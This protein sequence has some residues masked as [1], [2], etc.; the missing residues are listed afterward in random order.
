MMSRL[1][2]LIRQS[3]Q[4]RTKS[5]LTRRNFG[6][7]H[8]DLPLG[9]SLISAGLLRREDLQ[10]SLAR[11]SIS[12]GRLGELLIEVGLI[13]EDRLLPFLGQRLGV[14]GVRLRDGMV[15]PHV[16]RTLPRSIAERLSVL[17]MF[18]V[19][20]TLTVAMAD[21]QD[22]L[23]ID[24]IEQLTGL[25]VRPVLAL[26]SSIERFL[27]RC[28]EDD[29]GTN[30]VA[31]SF[32]DNA[33]E[34]HPEVVRVD[35]N[36]LNEQVEGSPIISMVN[37]ILVHAVRQGASDI[38]I[39]AGRKHS[40]VR[41][42]VDGRLREVLRPRGDFHA[43]LIS[44][45]KAMARMDIAEN[46]R[47][48]DGRVHVIVEGRE[49]DLRASTLPTVL[50]EK[51]VLRVLDSTSVTFRMGD[52]GVS[53]SQQSQIEAMMK[54]PHG[55]ILVTGPTGSGKT[56]TLY[57]A[58]ELIKDIHTNIVT[59]EDPVEY[60][61]DL[62]NQVDAAQGSQVTFASA[63]RAILR[64]DPDVIMIG[65]IRDAETAEIATQA[66]LTGHLVLSTLHANDNAGAITRLR[67][68]GIASYKLSASLVGVV[69]QRLLR[70][71]CPKCQ[72]NYFPSSEV[73]DRLG[74]KGD[75]RRQFVRGEGCP[76]CFDTG[77]RGR[78]GIYEVL[79]VTEGLREMMT[80]E[81]NSHSVRRW[82]Q[83]NGGQLLLQQGIVL[84]EKGLTSPDEVLRVAATD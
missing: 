9:E 29:A 50:G 67:D 81:L 11:Q 17:A 79:T 12:G 6:L 2:E 22:L 75:R 24:E 63:L 77:F 35:L 19:H 1:S 84:A 68:M 83:Q 71:I 16:V 37:Y 82:Y 23:Q 3:G 73:L 66:A 78:M 30:E 52:L 28:Y 53:P 27:A 76:N 56:T 60:S 55:L 10:G 48:Q 21:P 59:V 69:S 64:Q 58:L 47:P 13:D 20:Q 14:P 57:S 44:R 26:R 18:R 72:K 4:S 80:P 54:R 39:E 25:K 41:F 74:Y 40:S 43:A 38:H 46:H 31:K 15:D 61:L 32:D 65:E 49:I 70:T 33:V 36:D 51:L 45:L 34:E 42:R 7:I 62:I 5:L 8:N